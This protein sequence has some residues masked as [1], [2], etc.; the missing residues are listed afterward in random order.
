MGNGR[1]NSPGFFHLDPDAGGIAAC[2]L[3]RARSGVAAKWPCRGH[4]G[5]NQKGAV[6]QSGGYK[7]RGIAQVDNKLEASKSLGRLSFTAD[8]LF[9]YDGDA[10]ATQRLNQAVHAIA[11]NRYDEYGIPAATNSGRFQYT[12]QACRSP[13]LS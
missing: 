12:G 7:R 1:N 4:P 9:A 3:P 2:P 8:T 5:A 6:E 10:L 11:I 13:R